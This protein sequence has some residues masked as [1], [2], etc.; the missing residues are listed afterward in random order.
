MLASFLKDISRHIFENSYCV[1][2]ILIGLET[3]SPPRASKE[4]FS[5]DQASFKRP[6]LARA[7][8]RK[9]GSKGRWQL[10]NSLVKKNKVAKKVVSLHFHKHS[11][12]FVKEKRADK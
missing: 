9:G 3:T 2:L 7:H 6:G 11:K 8:S 12:L 10:P 4:E 5:L 1:L